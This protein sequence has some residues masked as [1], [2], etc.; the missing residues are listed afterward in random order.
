[1]G[2]V[3]DVAYTAPTCPVSRSQ[4]TPSQPGI[5][6]KVVPPATDLPS[7]IQSVNTLNQYIQNVWGAP[8]TNNTITYVPLAPTIIVHNVTTIT[9][10]PKQGFVFGPSF[11][12][13]L[14]QY[15]VQ[16]PMTV[17]SQENDTDRVEVLRFYELDMMDTETNSR[18]MD[19]FFHDSAD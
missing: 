4:P 19:L 2:K 14:E 9:T 15:R 1:M 10:A 6:F 13:W 7:A 5:L 3:R 11:P 12:N 8:A 16:S 18:E 17:Y